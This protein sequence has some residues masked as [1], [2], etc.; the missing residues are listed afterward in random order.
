MSRLLTLVV[1]AWLAVSACSSLSA[2]PSEAPARG[3]T[4]GALR[5]SSEPAAAPAAGEWTAASLRPEAAVAEPAS[6]QGAFSGMS[7]RH[8]TFL[9]GER[10]LDDD[11]WDPVEDQLATGVEVD[12]TDPDSGHGYEFGLTYS[13]DDDDVGPVDV[14]ASTFDVYGGYRYTFQPGDQGIHPYVSAGLAVIYGNVELDGPG[15]SPDDDDT[16]PGAYVRAGIGFDLTE[17]ARLGIDYR[18][19]FFTDVDIFGISDADFDQFM[20]TLGFAF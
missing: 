1:P 20:L 19:L 10:Q 18:H 14:E 8:V 16:S 15:A 12:G 13:Q 5:V 17:N 6:P 3:F 4:L 9:V 7:S 2:E 11:D